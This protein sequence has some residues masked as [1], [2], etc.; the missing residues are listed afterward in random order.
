MKYQ[1]QTKIHKDINKDKVSIFL[2][3]GKDGGF[4]APA[5]LQCHY[6]SIYL[7]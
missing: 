1:K 4:L 7:I 3:I 5:S 6:L 2:I